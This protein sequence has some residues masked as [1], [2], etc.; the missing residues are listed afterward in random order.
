MEPPL[1]DMTT[2]FDLVQS[3]FNGKMIRLEKLYRASEDGFN[4]TAYHA[5]CNNIENILNVVESE[6]GKKFG[7]YS[8]VKFDSTNSKWYADEKSF[9]FSLTERKKFDIIDSTSDKAFH[10]DPRLYIN[11]YGEG[12]DYAIS[13]DCDKNERSQSK[14][15]KTFKAP[16]GIT[17]N[18]E[19]SK[20][21]LAGSY[22]FKVKEVE[23]YKVIFI[24]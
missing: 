14:I 19:Q 7:G 11:I 10:A 9:I 23:A 15:G 1:I 18:T 8:S 12:F 17:F 3:W 5:K 16:E 13:K 2:E 24:E 4:G 6:H 20:S 21:Y 22:N